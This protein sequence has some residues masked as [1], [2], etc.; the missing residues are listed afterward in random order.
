MLAVA[1]LAGM[2]LVTTPAGTSTRRL[3]DQALASAAVTTRVA[4]ETGQ[5]EAIIPLVLAGAGTSF[6][7]ASFAAEA[8]RQGAVVATLDPPLHRRIGLIHRRG[9]L[10][11]AARSFTEL[12]VTSV[13]VSAPA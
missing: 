13:S 2:P 12:A 4:V 7:P 5:R 11:P 10:T 6:L 3:L 8:G 9:P 1:R